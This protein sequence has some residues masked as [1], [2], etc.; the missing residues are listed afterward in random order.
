MHDIFVKNTDVAVW[1][2]LQIIYFEWITLI[3][4]FFGLT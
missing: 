2:R 1:E 4:V 3:S